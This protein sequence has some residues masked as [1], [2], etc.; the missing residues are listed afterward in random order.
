VVDLRS[1]RP[2]QV[3]QPPLPLRTA[4]PSSVPR[5]ELTPT[6]YLAHP[7]SDFPSSQYKHNGDF[8]MRRGH[9]LR[10]QKQGTHSIDIHSSSSLSPIMRVQIIRVRLKVVN[11]RPKIW[12]FRHTSC[13]IISALPKT[14]ACFFR[15]SVSVRGRWAPSRM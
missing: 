14:R 6:L 9:L 11:I 15:N 8:P 12:M 4:I 2:I 3:N 13:C 5:Q 1:S 7:T 10:V